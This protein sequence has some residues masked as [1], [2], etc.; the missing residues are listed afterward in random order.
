MNYKGETEYGPRT[1]NHRSPLHEEPGYTP[2]FTGR[3]ELD[4]VRAIRTGGIPAVKT[5][6]KHPN[7]DLACDSPTQLLEILCCSGK[8]VAQCSTAATGEEELFNVCYENG[9]RNNGP[10]TKSPKTF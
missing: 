1:R 2:T 3:I 5:R 9:T 10:F 7:R 8:K 4:F 6:P